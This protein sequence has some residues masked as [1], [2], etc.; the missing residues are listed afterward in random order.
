VTHLLIILQLLLSLRPKL[1][2]ENKILFRLNNKI[3]RTF[4][5]I[6]LF[7]FL[8]ACS[9]RDMIFWRNRKKN[10]IILP[11]MRGRILSCMVLFPD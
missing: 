2:M 6:V 1:L 10:S 5:S 7:Y 11:T 9:H 3:L 4:L 8:F